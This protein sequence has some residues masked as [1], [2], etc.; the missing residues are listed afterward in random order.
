MISAAEDPLRTRTARSVSFTVDGQPAQCLEGQTI[1]GALL[2]TGRLSWR[3]TS[4]EAA[5][6]GAFCGIGV[7]FDCLVTVDGLRDV[8]ACLRRV[9]EGDEIRTQRDE[10]RTGSS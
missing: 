8:R 10:R 4:V 3:E 2:A 7:C 9:R 5:P 1:A 6:R